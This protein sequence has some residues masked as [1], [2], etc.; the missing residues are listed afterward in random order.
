RGGLEAA[1][2]A[3][4]VE[5]RIEAGRATYPEVYALA[6]WELLRGKLGPA[7]THA[8]KALSLRPGDA[9][10]QTLLGNVAFAESRWPEAIAAYIRPSERDA[11]LPAPRWTVPRVS[12][13]RAKTLPDDALGPEL[14]RAQTPA[15]AAQRLDERLMPRN[16]PPDTRPAMNVTILPPALSRGEPL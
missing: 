15:A 10:A 8:E 4:H 9:R 2:A 12:R 11:T 13:G 7:K 16:D 5:A 6:R 3:A 1:P 14:D